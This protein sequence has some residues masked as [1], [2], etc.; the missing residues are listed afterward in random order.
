MVALVLER[1][2]YMGANFVSGGGRP[3]SVDVLAPLDQVEHVTL[4]NRALNVCVL[5]YTKSVI[6]NEKGLDSQGAGLRTVFVFSF[7]AGRRRRSAAVSRRHH[8]GYASKSRAL[9]M[10]TDGSP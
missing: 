5:H 4:V 2:G 9:T 8:K 10:L 3:Y 1:G 7:F 6:S